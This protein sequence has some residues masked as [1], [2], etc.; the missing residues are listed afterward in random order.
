MPRSHNQVIIS[1]LIS[2]ARIFR[3]TP[4]ANIFG[5]IPYV[6]FVDASQRPKFSFKTS[7]DFPVP[8][9]SKIFSVRS[10]VG[11]PDASHKLKFSA[12]SSAGFSDASHEPKYSTRSSTG[13][14]DASHKPTFSVR[15]STDF[16]NA[17]Q[18]SGRQ[19]QC[20]TY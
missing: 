7:V 5:Q 11:F 20:W 4:Q 13:L 6:G 9:I 8:P 18:K 3:I 12:R 2:C 19:I 16:S 17:T 10:N 14:S 1:I 15:S